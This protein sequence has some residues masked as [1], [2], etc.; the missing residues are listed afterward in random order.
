MV[1][2]VEAARDGAVHRSAGDLSERVGELDAVLDAAQRL[3][4]LADHGRC[5]LVPDLGR[6]LK[7]KAV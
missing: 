6:P 4:V 3:A 5:V 7:A 2:L 1:Q